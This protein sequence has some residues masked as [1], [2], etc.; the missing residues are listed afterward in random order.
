MKDPCVNNIRCFILVMLFLLGESPVSE[1][2]V[3]TFRNV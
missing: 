1:V 2:C 3:P